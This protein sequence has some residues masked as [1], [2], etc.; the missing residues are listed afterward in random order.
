[1]IRQPTLET[2]VDLYKLHLT[3]YALFTK[4]LKYLNPLFTIT[5]PLTC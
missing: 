2:S 1:M 5:T 3:F 4:F